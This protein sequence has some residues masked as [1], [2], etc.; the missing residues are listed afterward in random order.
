MR[1]ASPIIAWLRSRMPGPSSGS[2]RLRAISPGNRLKGYP[3]QQEMQ[4]FYN[5]P[6]LLFSYALRFVARKMIVMVQKQ[7]E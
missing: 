6:F 5:H 3:S 1:E 7:D 2:L 4:F